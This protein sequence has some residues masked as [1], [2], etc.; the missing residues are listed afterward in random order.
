MGLEP[1]SVM[2]VY[3]GFTLDE[4]GIAMH[5]RSLIGAMFYLSLGIQM[6]EAAPTHSQRWKT[7]CTLMPI[8][9]VAM[10]K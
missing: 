9:S 2:K 6:P 3:D 7:I 5:P 1:R 8:S 4:E 10:A